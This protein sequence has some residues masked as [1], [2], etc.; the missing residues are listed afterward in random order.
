[1][2]TVLVGA[3]LAGAAGLIGRSIARSLRAV[4]T[5]LQGA[6]DAVRRAAAGVAASSEETRHDAEAVA[7]AARDVA[8]NVESSATTSDH[9]A[10]SIARIAAGTTEATQVA[11]EAVRAVAAA[12]AS[13]G[14]LQ[15]S[16]AQINH[17]VE[18]IA[19]IAAQTNL[20]ALNATIEAAR[21]GDAGR[22][23]AVVAG[24]VK[25]LAAQTA[26][27]TGQI[28]GQVSRIQND[29]ASAETQIRRISEV[30]TH[31][32]DVQAGVSLS[33]E[34][35]TTGTEQLAQS[36]QRAAN[37][38]TAITNAAESVVNTAQRATQS[39][40]TS[41]TAATDLEQALNA[42]RRLL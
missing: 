27:A 7:S 39:L 42:L 37:S 26:V 12:S 8:A 22:G 17:V 41:R 24:E 34:E 32:A 33:L 16:S 2:L 3:V 6:V 19:N 4:S 9:F 30:I 21:A 40:T 20:L 31:I 13:V 15:E 35:Q 23:F 14:S 5:V 25:E 36:T 38:T 28:T 10:S 11:D 18:L 29:T 1:M